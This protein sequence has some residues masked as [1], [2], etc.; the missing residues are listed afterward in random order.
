M[1]LIRILLS[2]LLITACKL[3]FCQEAELARAE[4]LY[5]AGKAAQALELI[6][7]IL[8]EQPEHHDALFLRARCYL[9]QLKRTED[10]MADLAAL[11]A[12]HPDSSR[13][14]SNRAYLYNEFGMFGRALLDAEEGLART[15][16]TALKCSLLNSG[17]WALKNLRRPDEGMIMARRCIALDS[18]STRAWNNLA[19][20][21]FMLND[22]ATGFA[23]LRQYAHVD[24]KD[25][26][27][28]ANTARYLSEHGRYREALSYFD[29]AEKMYKPDARF[30]NN[31]GHAHLGA[32]NLKQAKKDIER[33]IKMAP[34]NSYAYRNLAL[35]HLARKDTQAACTALS[36]AL[37]LGYQ[38]QYGD[39]VHQLLQQ[40]CKH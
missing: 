34:S 5:S 20:N 18:L 40:N 30:Y 26:I 32:G 31:R 27:S 35:L 36:R 2:G 11:I 3:G 17:S 9:Y 1:S 22:T 25:P 13:A 19:M 4:A 29:R 7:P 8:A 14:L 21:A 38:N 12:A 37:A 33:S 39:D 15:G 6:T 10:G 28:Q 23:A 24:A 16:D